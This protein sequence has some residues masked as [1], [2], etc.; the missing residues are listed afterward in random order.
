MSALDELLKQIPDDYDEVDVAN[1]LLHYRQAAA[2]ELAKLRAD[3]DE[4]QQRYD[5]TMPCGHKNRYL[6]V[7]P[8]GDLQFDANG[9]VICLMCYCGDEVST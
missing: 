6:L 4:L 9:Y 5:I 3:N 1:H 8:N 7:K 2:E